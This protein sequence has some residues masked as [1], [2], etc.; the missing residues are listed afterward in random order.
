MLLGR[1]FG[2]EG[3]SLKFKEGLV[4]DIMLELNS[5]CEQQLAKGP[6]RGKD[7][8]NVWSSMGKIP[9]PEQARSWL[10]K[11]DY[12]IWLAWVREAK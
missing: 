10:E 11:S 1:N 8:S 4:R 9:R 3:R 6:E 7:I 5:V 2:R 12:F